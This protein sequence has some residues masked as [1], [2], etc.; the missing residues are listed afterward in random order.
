M[1]ERIT[2]RC[3][4]S[5]E[6]VEIKKLIRVEAS[7]AYCKLV[8]LDENPIILSCPLKEI[9][10]KLVPYPVFFRCHKSHLINISYVKSYHSDNGIKLTDGFYIPLAPGLKAT[11]MEKTEKLFG[12]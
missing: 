4:R 1:N 8:I 11:F 5:I 3:S 10:L 7:R 2:I 9:E 12:K 6:F